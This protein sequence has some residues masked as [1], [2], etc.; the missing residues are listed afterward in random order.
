MGGNA[1]PLIAN[2]YLSW[3]E[4]KYLDKLVKNKEFNLVNYLKYNCRF[5]H[6]IV[7]PNVDN[8]TTIASD[9]SPED[10]PLEQSSNIGTHDTFL[11]LDISVLDNKFVFK[12]FHK[13]DLFNFEVISFPYL[14]SNAPSQICYNTFFSQLITFANICSNFAGFAEQVKL[15]F[16]KL[17]ARKYDKELL[18]RTFHK[19]V[20]QYSDIVLGFTP[21]IQHLLQ[22]CLDFQN[23]V[24]PVDIDQNNTVDSTTH[25]LSYLPSRKPVGLYNLGN[26]CYLNSILQIFFQ[27]GL[28][29]RWIN[30]VLSID[31]TKCIDYNKLLAF[32]T[33]LHLFKVDTISHGQ[34]SDFV[35]ILYNIDQFF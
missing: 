1:S 2:L 35:S 28:Y 29:D 32:E 30:H 7:T 13:V 34:Y 18:E 4:Y 10:I 6:D 24:P 26:T 20:C 23:C 12:I 33:F 5:N 17:L 3:L 21:N 22:S 31:K 14:E 8:F 16:N 15:F 9:I 19:F 11:D 25:T 27:F